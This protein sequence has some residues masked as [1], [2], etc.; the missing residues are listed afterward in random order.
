MELGCHGI[1]YLAS[2]H[3]ILPSLELSY[4]CA[5]KLAQKL[6]AFGGL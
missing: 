5:S 6:S 3:A 1:D 4:V 2:E